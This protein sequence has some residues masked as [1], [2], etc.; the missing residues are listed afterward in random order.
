MIGRLLHLF[1]LSRAHG[2]ARRYF[3]TNGFDGALTMLGLLLGFYLSEFA[4]LSTVITACL[5]AAVALCISGLSSA[6]ISEAAERQKEL[7]ELEQAMVS[8][9][10][11][12][13]HQ[14]AARITPVLVALANGLAPLLISLFIISPLWMARAGIPLPLQPL[15]CAMALAFVAVFFIGVFLSRV[16]GHFWLWSGLFATAVAVS[17]TLLIMMIERMAP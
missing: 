9:M 12:S 3:V 14:A 4:A 11:G 8:P 17:T 16:S 1:Y 13:A 15:E 6:Y 10:T 2:I 5:G 7:R